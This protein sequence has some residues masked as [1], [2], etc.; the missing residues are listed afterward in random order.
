MIK[1][2]KVPI[3]PGMSWRHVYYTAPLKPEPVH[4]HDEFELSL[5]IGCSGVLEVSHST[6]AFNDI[7]LV[8]I[9]PNK[10]HSSYQL[11][12]IEEH[13]QQHRVW[14]NA[15]WVRNMIYFCPEMRKLDK[16]LHRVKNGV[17]FSKET[18]LAVNRELELL[19]CNVPKMEQLTVCIRVLSLL[20]QDRNPIMLDVPEKTTYLESE[21]T[22][23]D[24]VDA[25]SQYIA[26]HYSQ[27]ITLDELA[28]KFFISRSTLHRLFL[29]NF[30]ETFVQRLKKTRL[31]HAERLLESSSYSIGLIA[32][33][34][35]YESQS[36]F[37][38]QFKE[39]RG[40]SP[41]EYRLN[42]TGTKS[43][44]QGKL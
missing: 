25:I 38:R 12:P 6:L 29:S 22:Q 27:R 14:I 11:E 8:M 21:L 33:K 40:V 24:K 30:G 15:E 37:N 35:G 39:Y 43:R 2:E 17:K 16:L 41:R 32:E 7:Q 34:V 10:P 3:R 36:N 26:E 13:A 5:F 18:A 31:G 42:H 1:V 23:P 9:P 44:E 4:Q 19:D 20:S 28:D